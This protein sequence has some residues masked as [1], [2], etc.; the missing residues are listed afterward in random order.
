M[1]SQQKGPTPQESGIDADESRQVHTPFAMNSMLPTEKATF[2]GANRRLG[3]P[4]VPAG[5]KSCYATKRVSHRESARVEI[6]GLNRVAI[7]DRLQTLRK[8]E[9]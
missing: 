7:T 1:I 6:P 5:D 8:P 2:Q 3:K 9:S 4:G